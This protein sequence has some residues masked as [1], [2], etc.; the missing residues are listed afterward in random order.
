MSQ[1]KRIKIV[2]PKGKLQWFKLI[3]PDTKFKKYQVDLVVED[4]PELQ[5]LI[6]KMEE[7]INDRIE[8]EL[9]KAKNPQQKKNVVAAKFSPINEEYDSQGEPT[10]KYVLKFRAPSEG[11]T[12]EG[13]IYTRPSPAIFDEKGKPIVGLAKDALK[14]M[15][16]SIGRISA[17]LNTYFTPSLGVGVTLLPKA[18]LIH[19][20]AEAGTD[21][22][23]FGF[24]P[25]EVADTEEESGFT[26]EGDNHEVDF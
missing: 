13:E 17:E 5:K 11:K 8:I 10:G 23:E 21:I 14:V 20:M 19:S 26:D 15:N 6:S 18:C 24:D 12:K 7:A 25:I 9:E 2:S 4:S 22:S 3:K 16:G 1:N